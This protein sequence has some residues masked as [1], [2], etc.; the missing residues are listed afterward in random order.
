MG[1]PNAI[2]TTIE[3]AYGTNAKPIGIV[4]GREN[5]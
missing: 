1:V 2:N 4:R 5:M 3:I